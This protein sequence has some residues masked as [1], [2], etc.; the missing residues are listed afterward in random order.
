MASHEVICSVLAFLISEHSYGSPTGKEFAVNRAGVRS[1]QLGEAKEAF[2]E[3]REEAP[4]VVDRG[5][6][7]IEL[8]SSSFGTLADYLYAR[9]DGWTEDQIQLRL[10]HYEGWAEHRWSPPE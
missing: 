3:L 1:D 10:K 6:R 9:C 4:F 5:A 7:G 2:E 8:D